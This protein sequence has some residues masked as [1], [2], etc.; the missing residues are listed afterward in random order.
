MKPDDLLDRIEK[1]ISVGILDPRVTTFRVD[2]ILVGVTPI[3]TVRHIIERG[4][5]MGIRKFVTSPMQTYSVQKDR[6]GNSRNVIPFVDAAL[7]KDS[8]AQIKY[9]DAILEDGT[10]NWM[11]YYGLHRDQQRY[12]GSI[13]MIPKAEFVQPYINVM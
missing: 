12:P 13:A 9:G 11:K 1:L 3:D 6:N 5:K 7:K 10:Y 2:P 4:A 8:N